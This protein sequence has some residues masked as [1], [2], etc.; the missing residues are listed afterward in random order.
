MMDV[1]HEHEKDTHEQGW[2][3]FALKHFNTDNTDT[4]LKNIIL[5]NDPCLDY[6]FLLGKNYLYLLNTN[7]LEQI[8]KLKIPNNYFKTIDTSRILILTSNDA[9]YL[10]VYNN[11]HLLITCITPKTE[12]FVELRMDF[13]RENESLVKV[14]FLK[15]EVMINF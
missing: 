8:Q 2:K 4:E 11:N 14:Y 3:E 5:E 1:D 12:Q 10:I 15:N 7:T 9:K 13:L 6:T